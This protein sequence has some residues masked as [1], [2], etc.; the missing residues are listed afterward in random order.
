[1]A[2]PLE[3]PLRMNRNGS[4]QSGEDK[5]L[6][7][8]ISPGIFEA[9]Q[10]RVDE[11]VIR[12]R[13]T[14]EQEASWHE[15]LAA[16][17]DYG[18]AG[19]GQ[20]DSEQDPIPAA[21]VSHARCAARRDMPLDALLRSYH[22]GHA[23]LAKITTGHIDVSLEPRALRWILSLQARHSHLIVEI[24]AEYDREAK[25]IARSPVQH[26]AERVE[27]L[28]EGAS[29]DTSGLDYQFAHNWHVCVIAIGDRAEEAV[30]TLAEKLKRQLLLVPQGEEVAWAWLG[31]RRRLA[32]ADIEHASVTPHTPGVV[33]AVG[34]AEQDLDGWRLTHRQAQ[35]ALRIALHER[36]PLTR[37]VDAGL[38]APFLADRTLAYSFIDV[39]LSALSALG[40]GGAAARETLREY[41]KAG[42][43]VV[44]AAAAL[45]VD[46]STLRKRLATI[47]KRLGY[48]LRTRHT[49]L[50]VALRLEALV[51]AR[52]ELGG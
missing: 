50:E 6:A 41:F 32:I 22:A 31:G 44:A 25:R 14:V 26:R 38:L 49:E 1:M 35:A 20:G 8:V 27:R 23:E 18:L 33:L 48:V 21:I 51:G 43:Q 9:I 10:Q 45:K 39:H 46:R 7:A 29:S 4:K 36:Q 42:Q 16:A 40:D 17:V 28:L 19:L 13:E 52:R 3:Q 37:F 15:A 24:A 11:A 5:L 2:P 47:D 34:E 30:V 12:P